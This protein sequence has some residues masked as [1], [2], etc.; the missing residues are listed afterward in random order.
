MYLFVSKEILINFIVAFVSA[1]IVILASFITYKNLV[2]RRLENEQAHFDDRDYLSKIEDPYNL[3]QELEASDVKEVIKKE[4]KLLKQNK[5]GIKAIFSDSVNA[6]SF[7]RIL[8][9]VLLIGGFFYLLNKG[10]LNL[11]YYLLFLIFPTIIVLVY[12]LFEAKR[13]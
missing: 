1:S 13:K 3:D 8:A 11:K 12:L 9:Y 5:R 6:F 4:K 2:L 7:E 10:Y